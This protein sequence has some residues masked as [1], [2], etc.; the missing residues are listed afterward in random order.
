MNKIHLSCEAQDDL[1]EIKSYISTELDNPA[2]ALRTVDRVTKS[3]RILQTHAGAGAL[4]SS[5][6]NVD[7]DYRFLVSGSY[8]SFYRVNGSDVY[9][10]RVLYGRRDYLRIL[11][12]DAQEEPIE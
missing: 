5:I 12:G 10:D 1:A 3:I 8:M 7:S 4:L 11:F 6:A 2:A 9:V